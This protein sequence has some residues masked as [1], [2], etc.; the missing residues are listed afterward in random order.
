M[1]QLKTTAFQTTESCSCCCTRNERDSCTRYI[2]SIHFTFA[3]LNASGRV[4]SIGGYDGDWTDTVYHYNVDTDT[5]ELLKWKLPVKNIQFAA[6]YI[7]PYLCIFG[8]HNGDVETSSCHRCHLF[9]PKHKWEALP[10]LPAPTCG[11]SC[12]VI[13]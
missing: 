13:D 12:L 3:S 2:L 4:C 8:G 9:H 6:C 1:E 5:W 11:L 7:S 10:S